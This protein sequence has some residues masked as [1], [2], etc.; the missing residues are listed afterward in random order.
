MHTRQ[1]RNRNAEYERGQERAHDRADL[2]HVSAVS[3]DVS[4]SYYKDC[5]ETKPYLTKT[6]SGQIAIAATSSAMRATQGRWWWI[7]RT[8]SR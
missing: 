4:V 3:L 6:Y 8:P 7:A 1:R 2:R 5:A